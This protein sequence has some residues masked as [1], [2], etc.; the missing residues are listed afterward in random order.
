MS[1]RTPAQEALLSYQQADQD[2]VMVLVSRQAIH[3][4]LN[5]IEVREKAA[6]RRFAAT[7]QDEWKSQ[8]IEK[9]MAFLRDA[10]R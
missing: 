3:E 9:M 1:N 2:G 7:V 10:A 6:V 5:E 8:G 4:V